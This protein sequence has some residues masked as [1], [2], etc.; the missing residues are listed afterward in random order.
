ML[1]Q[2]VSLLPSLLRENGNALPWTS[3][4]FLRKSEGFPALVERIDI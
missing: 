2:N 1:H 4:V 3:H